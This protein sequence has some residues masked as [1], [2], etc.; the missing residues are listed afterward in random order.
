MPE[1]LNKKIIAF[2]LLLLS[3]IL[4]S[5]VYVI[6]VSAKLHSFIDLYLPAFDADLPQLTLINNK[7]QMEGELPRVVELDKGV[8]IVFN[9]Q[10]ADSLFATLPPKSIFVTSE[11]IWYKTVKDT[12][13]LSFAS[14]DTEQE[15][16]VVKP[17]KIEQFFN[18][19]TNIIV[20]GV[21]L[22]FFVLLWI[23]FSLM[24]F[25]LGGIGTMIDA[26]RSGPFSF[27]LY[28]N[29]GSFFLFLLALLSILFQPFSVERLAVTTATL[30]LIYLILVFILI[31]YGKHKQ[32]IANL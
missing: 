10:M 4:F 23:L 2:V 3:A 5:L 31:Q 25:F 8:K 9:E 24:A 7:L 6:P 20:W 18:H 12:V 26:F 15:E 22:L 17:A 16:V 14:F 30:C 29:I 27:S 19:Y 13:K 1:F 21:G 28:L 11:Q 32:R